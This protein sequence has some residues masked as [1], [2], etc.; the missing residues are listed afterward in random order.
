MKLLK[1]SFDGLNMFKDGKLTLDFF[2]TDRVVDQ[3]GVTCIEKPIYSENIMAFAGINATG[4]TTT[5]RLIAL[6]VN[7]L[8]GGSVAVPM[9]DPCFSS[10][11]SEHLKIDAI[12]SHNEAFY[13]LVSVINQNQGG[14]IAE[15]AFVSEILW[16]KRSLIV[17]KRVLEDP[18]RFSAEAVQ[19]AKRNELSEQVLAYLPDSVSVVSALTKGDRQFVSLSVPS[20]AEWLRFGDSLV[21]DVIVKAFDKSIRHVD[22]GEVWTSVEFE[23]GSSIGTTH[24]RELS[25][26]LSSGTIK[27]ANIIQCAIDAL[28]TGGYLLVDEIENHLNKQLV[29]MIIDLFESNDTN[30]HGATLLFSTHYPEV[31]DY[32]KRKDN[33]YFLVR[34][35][36]HLVSAIRYSD[37]VKRIENKKSEVFLANYIAGTAPRYADVA[38]LKSFIKRAVRNDGDA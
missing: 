14:S 25:R 24:A 29:G 1:V 38:E 34:D 22:F 23:T 37:R 32:L 17:S 16:E 11:V 27:G 13:R 20:D 36:E 26:S 28:K 2:A 5:L 7:L 4:K 3:R 12:F 19:I 9:Q 33:V 18:E 10:T 8:S 15:P 30:P 6:A 31:L 35:E 21:E